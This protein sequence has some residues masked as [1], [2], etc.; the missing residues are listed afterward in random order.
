MGKKRKR[1]FNLSLAMRVLTAAAFM[2]CLSAGN[3]AE[4][5]KSDDERERVSLD[6][7][8]TDNPCRQSVCLNGEWD[9]MPMGA[10]SGDGSK[11]DA[12][13]YP[14]EG[15]WAAKKIRVPASW[16]NVIG[17]FDFPQYGQGLHKAWYRKS[18]VI[19]ESMAG[20]RIFLDFTEVS[21][22][23]NVYLNGT[24]VGRHIGDALAFDFDITP[25]AKVGQTNILEVGVI[26]WVNAIVD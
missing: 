16:N 20:Q 6:Y 19:P 4:K 1:T 7:T 14:P 5:Q 15:K 9:F 12:L 22:D 10:Y 26:N 18:I 8:W 25:C 2:I 3:A 13:T 23:A 17:E 21:Y 11:P 24:F